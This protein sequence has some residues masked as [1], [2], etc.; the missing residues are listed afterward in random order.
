MTEMLIVTGS[1]RPNSA[2][3]NVVKAIQAVVQSRDDVEATVADLAELNLP[4]LNANPIP[5]DANYEITEPSVQ[6]WSDMVSSAD[7][8][9]FVLPE[10][11]HNMSAISKNALDWLFVEWNA[12]PV[13]GVA[14]GWHNGKSAAAALDDGLKVVKATIVEPITQL[15]FME[16]IGVDGSVTNQEAFDERV[17]ATIDQLVKTVQ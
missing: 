12:K 14:Y 16:V 8:V 1:A 2:N 13:S 17:N 5:S 10:Y 6:A 4:F 9:L 3:Q 11:N 7:A 15:Q